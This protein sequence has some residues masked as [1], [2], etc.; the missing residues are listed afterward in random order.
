MVMKSDARRVFLSLVAIVPDPFRRAQDALP[1]VLE[2]FRDRG[3]GMRHDDRA[4]RLAALQKRGI[5][6][7][8]IGFAGLTFQRNRLASAA[9]AP[10]GFVGTIL[11]V[12]EVGPSLAVIHRRR[13]A[14]H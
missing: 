1:R 8:E 11:V 5:G 2:R 6:F 14:H 9:E 7:L 4:P 10:A 13:L 12:G 3:T